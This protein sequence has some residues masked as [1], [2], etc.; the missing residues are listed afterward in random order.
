MANKV[1]ENNPYPMELKFEKIYKESV[2]LAKKRYC[3]NKMEKPDDEPVLDAKGIELIRRDTVE[4]TQIIM[5]KCIRILFE[6]KDL[7]QVKKYLIR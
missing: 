7:S 3:G 6:T 1:T 5:D 2:I 4:A